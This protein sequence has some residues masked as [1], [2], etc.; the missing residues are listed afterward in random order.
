METVKQPSAWPTRKLSAGMLAAAATQIMTPWLDQLA[1]LHWAVAG[2]SGDA[3][4][5]L[6]S[7]GVGM[8]VGYFVKDTP[9]V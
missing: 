5:A 3:V 1:G 9:N 6:V 2:F 7:V 8:A 4:K